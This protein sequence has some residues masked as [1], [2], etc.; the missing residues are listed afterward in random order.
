MNL[1][2][3]AICAPNEIFVG[4]PG[5]GGVVRQ[6]NWHRVPDAY[7][8]QIGQGVDMTP[9]GLQAV[10]MR[11]RRKSQTCDSTPGIWKMDR[12]PLL[13]PNTPDELRRRK[14]RRAELRVRMGKTVRGCA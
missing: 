9:K 13:S 4:E 6:G 1:R 8:F 7:N 2:V 10:S 12:A 5:E 11:S 14:T 3:G